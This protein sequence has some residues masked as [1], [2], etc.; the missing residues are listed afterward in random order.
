MNLPAPSHAILYGE[1]VLS[2][3]P[4][5]IKTVNTNIFTQLLSRFLVFPLLSLLFGSWRDFSLIW[6]NPYESAVSILH[7]MLN[8][9][10]VAASYI[11]YK[12]LSIGSAISIFYLYP[13]LNLI[14]AYFL[15]NEKLAPLNI[16]LIL[17]A[18]IGVYLISISY[19]KNKSDEPNTSDNTNKKD[20]ILG[21]ISALLAA[22]T[23]TMIF[24]FVRT[25]NYAR[26]S[27]FYTVNHL[28]PAGLVMLVLYAIFNPEKVD[29]NNI[30][31]A[32]LIG[33]NAL[34]GFTGYMARF[35]AIPKISTMLLSLLVFI[36]VGFGYLWDIL[37]IGDKISHKAIIGSS[38]IA[39]SIGLMRYFGNV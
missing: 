1:L 31:W 18:F 12:N 20:H 27:P 24:I 8:M 35:Y 32:K 15:F 38:L 19:N 9:G 17:I 3:Y 29:T 34:L 33:F 10:N 4:I 16:L 14:V 28:Y 7:S 13:I 30:N 26:A 2:L 5:L 21:I 23:E 11:S 22:V 6:G 25:N 39:G 36:G 37:I